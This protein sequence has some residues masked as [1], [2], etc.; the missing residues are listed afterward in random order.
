MSLES[1]RKLAD[2]RRRLMEVLR[3]IQDEVKELDGQLAAE[4]V[5]RV[6][7]LDRRIAEKDERDAAR[8]RWESNPTAFN[9]VA[10]DR[11]DT[12]EGT[13]VA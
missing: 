5:K 1:E 13:E 3:V 10:E 6:A 9:E 2:R 11:R 8:K 12:E 4:R 7:D